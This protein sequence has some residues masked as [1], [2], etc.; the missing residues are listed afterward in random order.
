MATLTRWRKYVPKWLGNAESPEPFAVEVKR[1]T[2]GERR[3]FL[4]VLQDDKASD[5][6]RVAMFLP[7]LRGPLGSL[8][9]DGERVTTIEQLVSIALEETGDAG[10]LL[11]ELVEAVLEGSALGK[12]LRESSVPASGGSGMSASEAA[13]PAPTV[14]AVAAS[15]PAVSTTS[16]G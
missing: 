11:G 8:V 3:A 16:G 4:E 9:I 5:E 15:S 13:P 7:L 1:A 10:N 6:A 14:L 2:W 12:A